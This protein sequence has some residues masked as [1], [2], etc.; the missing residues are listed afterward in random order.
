[1][2]SNISCQQNIGQ[3]D[4][5]AYK[6]ETKFRNEYQD[7]KTNKT[8][9]YIEGTIILKEHA[10]RVKHEDLR[11]YS[12]PNDEAYSKIIDQYHP[13]EDDMFL[14]YKTKDQLRLIFPNE[15]GY[16]EKEETEYI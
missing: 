9:S 13:D 7:W 12:Y 5:V 11:F 2:D 3:E 1:M 15:D 8:L 14:F 10:D 6:E 16:T 4:I